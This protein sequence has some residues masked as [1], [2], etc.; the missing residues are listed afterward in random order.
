LL[1]DREANEAYCLTEPGKQ[2]AVYFPESGTVT[3][4][5]SDAGD[6]VILKWLNIIESEWS[7]EETIQAAETIE[8]TAPGDGQWA[9]LL[10]SKKHKIGK[11]T[12]SHIQPYSE[13]PHYLAWGETPVYGL[14]ATNYHSWTPISRPENV[15]FQKDLQRLAQVIERINSPHVRGFVRC[16]PYDP[17]NHMHDGDLD[18]VLQ[19]W[20]KME[21]G[22]YNLE[23]FEPE[24][25]NHYH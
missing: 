14:G 20:L 24:W 19:P 22:R 16:L 4:N 25:E 18:R 6:E 5:L 10:L 12:N 13:N 7:H 15:D 3:L 2:Y 11:T 8:L 9:A 21:D 23:R 17:M 1:Q